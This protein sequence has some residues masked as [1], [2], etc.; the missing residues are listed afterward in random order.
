[1]VTQKIGAHVWRV[2]VDV[3]RQLF[4]LT[5]IKN[6]IFF[7]ISFLNF[8]FHK[9]ATCAGLPCNISTMIVILAF[10]LEFWIDEYFGAD[11]EPKNLDRT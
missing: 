4:R 9:C 11:P 6:W 10:T 2:M 5:A 7:N 1:M 8:L 3:F